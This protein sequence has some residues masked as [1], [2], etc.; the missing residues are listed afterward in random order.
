[1]LFSER[2]T[3]KYQKEINNTIELAVPISER[4]K[5]GYEKQQRFLYPKAY[6]N[7]NNTM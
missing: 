2:E 4:I 6:N 5:Y 3:F 7:N 1:M